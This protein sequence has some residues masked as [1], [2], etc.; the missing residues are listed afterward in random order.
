[1]K[2]AGIFW[3]T[4][5]TQGFFGYCTFLHFFWVD[6]S[7]VG[8]FLGIKYEP[9][10]DPPPLPSLKYLS[11]APGGKVFKLKRCFTYACKGK[12]NKKLIGKKIIYEARPG[13][14]IFFKI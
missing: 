14:R 1:M 10:S 12:N 2:D 7:E 9:L 3:V 6:N 5:K 8:F 4:K 13:A 11:G